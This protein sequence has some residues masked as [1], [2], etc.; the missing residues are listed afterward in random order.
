MVSL[1]TTDTMEA[2]LRR[3]LEGTHRTV[4]G[5]AMLKELVHALVY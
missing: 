4:E 2:N 5:K 1:S 3:F